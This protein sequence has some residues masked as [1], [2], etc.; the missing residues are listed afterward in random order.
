MSK[1]NQGHASHAL[2]IR[3]KSSIVRYNNALDDLETEIVGILQL[4]TL[5]L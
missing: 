3:V 5:V 1:F 4:G 2:R